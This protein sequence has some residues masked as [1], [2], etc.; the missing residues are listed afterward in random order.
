[1]WLSRLKI[2]LVSMKLQVRSLVLLS[3]LRIWRCHKLWCS[4]QMWLEPCIAM[5]VV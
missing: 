4:S 3:G 1:M 2:Q 5:A